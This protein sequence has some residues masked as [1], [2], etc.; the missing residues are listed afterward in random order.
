MSGRLSLRFHTE[1]VGKQITTLDHLTPA[2]LIHKKTN[3]YVC[4]N[5][6]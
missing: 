2:C 3:K 4:D 1:R 5:E 6:R